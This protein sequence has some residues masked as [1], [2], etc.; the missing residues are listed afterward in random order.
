[1]IF[2]RAP[3]SPVRLS[4]RVHV[5][6]IRRRARWST[7]GAKKEAVG[8]QC[9]VGGAAPLDAQGVTMVRFGVTRVRTVLETS[10]RGVRR[11][12]E[13]E[14][15]H[16]EVGAAVEEVSPPP[17]SP[18]STARRPSSLQRNLSMD[19]A[20]RC[21]FRTPTVCRLVQSFCA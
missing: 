19:S 4:E 21:T 10:L 12:E 7:G 6:S 9:G 2:S 15:A 1:M 20:S 11:V 18:D 8:V 14:V 5:I 17:D 3:R 16:V 13:D